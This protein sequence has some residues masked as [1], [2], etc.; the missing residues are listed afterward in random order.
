MDEFL[1]SVGDLQFPNAGQQRGVV[2]TIT[3]A[4][5]A[6]EFGCIVIGSNSAEV[7]AMQQELARRLETA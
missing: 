7:V 6:G 1:A 5:E 3:S 2:V 4:L